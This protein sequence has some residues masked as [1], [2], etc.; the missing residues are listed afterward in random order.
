MTKCSHSVA[1]ASERTIEATDDR[2]VRA[3]SVLGRDCGEVDQQPLG[4]AHFGI[5]RREHD[6][7]GLGVSWPRDPDLPAGTAR[8]A[9]RRCSRRTRPFARDTWPRT[10][11]TCVM[12]APAFTSRVASVCRAW[13]VVCPGRL[14][15]SNSS[16]SLK[17][18]E[19]V[20]GEI[21]RSKVGFL[22]RLGN[23]AMARRWAAVG[24][25]PVLLSKR[26]DRL[27]LPCPDYVVHAARNLDG[28]VELADLRHVDPHP[29]PAEVLA[30]AVE[31]QPD[32]LANTPA[33][34][35]LDRPDVAQ[36]RCREGRPSRRAGCSPDRSACR[37]AS[38]VNGR[39]F[40]N[41]VAPPY[42]IATMN[43]RRTPAELAAPESIA[44][45]ITLRSAF[46]TI[47]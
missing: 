11:L 2:P 36:C 40:L 23:R 18:T 22:I 39:G 21:D 20:D 28:V 33:A 46:M 25:D 15:S 43:S 30:D 26:L 19:N 5:G 41:E 44:Q 27:G 12:L 4:G 7:A 37:S 1:L 24:I 42:G 17:R 3:E 34:L 47:G 6:L 9:I 16:H 31:S 45:R 14:I 32:D 35:D 29:R 8:P 13:W 38:S 10:C